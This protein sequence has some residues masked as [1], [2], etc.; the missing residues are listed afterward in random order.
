MKVKYPQRVRSTR[1]SKPFRFRAPR[2]LDK[3]LLHEVYER[4]LAAFGHQAWWP[5]D[6]VFEVILGAILTQNTA[7]INVEK[8]LANLR[9]AGKMNV[10]A[11]R[12]MPEKTLAR[13]IRPAGYYNVK[14]KRIKNFMR[15]LETRYAGSLRKMAAEEGS[16]LR[17]GLLGVSGIGPETADSILL[18][19]FRKPFFVIDAYTKRVF[20]RHGLYSDSRDYHEWQKLFQDALAAR[21]D[22][23]NDFHAQ[24][25]HLAK[26]HCRAR[27]VRCDSCPLKCLL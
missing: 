10:D 2:R 21:T 6:T 17:E 7:W 14:A 22:L 1:P 4:L 24:I 8:A 27:E 11:V 9:S 16:A 12:K 19:A 5:G 15:F 18:Y 26:N 3:S 20:S 25:V 23:Y 13:L